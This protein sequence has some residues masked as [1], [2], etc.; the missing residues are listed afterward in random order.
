[1][2]EQFSTR[3]LDQAAL[4]EEPPGR[5]NAQPRDTRFLVR[6]LTR[7]QFHVCSSRPVRFD[8]IG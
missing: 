3:A 5:G 1:M 4:G 7:D 8:S 2:E 6:M